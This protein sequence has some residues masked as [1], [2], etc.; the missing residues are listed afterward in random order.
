MSNAGKS[1]HKRTLALIL[2]NDRG[3]TANFIETR[4]HGGA[5][6]RTYCTGSDFS[7]DLAVSKLSNAMLQEPEATSVNIRVRGRCEN[8]RRDPLKATIIVDACSGE[9][10]RIVVLTLVV[11]VQAFWRR[12]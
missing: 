8:N 7:G 1:D 3:A 9:Y 6:A 10:V 12:I 4:E 11:I 5:P 2:L